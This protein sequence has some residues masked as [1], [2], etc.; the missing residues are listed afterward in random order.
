MNNGEILKHQL[1]VFERYID[2]ALRLGID[3]VFIIHGLGKGKLKTEIA[4]RLATHPFVQTY[5]N[6][7]HPKYGWGATEVIF[8]D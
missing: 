4:K 1:W 2:Q 6:E 3:N 5:K 7:F 8:E